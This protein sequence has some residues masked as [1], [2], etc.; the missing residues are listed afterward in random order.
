LPHTV[1]RRSGIP[2]E[3]AAKVREQKPDKLYRS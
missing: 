3:P 1:E 2:F